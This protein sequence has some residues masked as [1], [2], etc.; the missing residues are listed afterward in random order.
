M[1]LN[2]VGKTSR[3]TTVSAVFLLSM[4]V[5]VLVINGIWRQQTSQEQ[6][7]AKQNI[8]NR[9]SELKYG[10]NECC[11][12]T[13]VMNLILQENAEGT[14]KDFNDVARHIMKDRKYI[15]C[16]QLAPDGTVTSIYPLEGNE[17][18][19][20]NLFEEKHYGS[21]AAYS[22]NTGT[23]TLQGPFE[24]PHN[25]VGLELRDPVYVRDGNGI[26]QFWGFA[27]AIVK[28]PDVFQISIDNLKTFGYDYALY[29]TNPFDDEMRLITSSR[30]IM[31]DPVVAEFDAAGVSWR[32]EIMPVDG[33][34][35]P[36]TLLP[37]ALFG[38]ILVL[39]LTTLTYMVML[40][41]EDRNIFSNISLR[42]QLT[43]LYNV[44]CFEEDMAALV[45]TNS[46]HGIF[47]IDVNKFKHINDT[48]GHRAGD[49]VLKEVALRIKGACDFKVYRLGGDEFAIMVD[50]EIKRSA[51]DKITNQMAKAFNRSIVSGSNHMMVSVSIGYAFY[52]DDG[53]DPQQLREIADQ[54]MYNMKQEY[55]ANME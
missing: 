18:D 2:N 49:D 32:L 53:T 24:T 5:L 44:R 20:I 28:V 13:E 14:M 16:L 45:R 41:A 51:Y 40:L 4:L 35:H 30:G 12:I 26:K 36:A 42:D 37:Y 55:H 8:Q 50:Q 7:L 23:M 39:L 10:I 46:L 6:T 1:N 27:I 31:E 54:R 15:S 47:F 33:W 21:L 9:V 43:G 34:A 52:P 11:G 19:L 25:E 3:I 38:L 48:Y 17:G 29:K 22:K